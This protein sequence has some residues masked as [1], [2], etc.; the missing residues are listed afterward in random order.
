MLGDRAALGPGC[1]MRSAYVLALNGIRRG[2]RNRTVVLMGVVGPLVLGGVLALAFGGS[3]PEI[4]IGVVDLDSS[5]L[6]AEV[7]AGLVGAFEDPEGDGGVVLTMEGAVDSIEGARRL[8]ADDEVGAVV[9]IP[10]GY[11]ASLGA[12]VATADAAPED[13]VVVAPAD[14]AVASAVAE[15]LARSVAGRADLQRA[16]LRA[17]VDSGGDAGSFDAD[18]LE[19][20]VRAEMSGYSGDFDAPMFLG[21][22]AVFLFLGLSVS[23]KSLVR[24]EQ[25]GILDRVRASSLSSWS[26]VAGS[27]GSVMVTGML[28]A[29]LVVVLSSLVFGAEWGDPLDVAVVLFAFVAS[30][31]GLLG[32]VAGVARTEQQADSW[33]N[34]MAFGFAVIGGSFFGGALLPGVLGFVGSLTPNGAAMLALMDAGPGGEGLAGVWPLV[35]WML[36]VG[37][38]GVF[39]GGVLMRRRLR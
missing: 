4:R 28:A 2:I 1:W 21:P 33:T 38:L 13:L 3:G 22:L 8:V 27:A 24:D 20:V 29:S 9:A 31:A 16:V 36:L 26:V 23:A 10:P 30:V 18:G 34:L 12:G 17:L 35:A 7:S 37:V 11:G 15:S 32:L 14:D 39:A 19:Q 6:S 5:Q 25:V